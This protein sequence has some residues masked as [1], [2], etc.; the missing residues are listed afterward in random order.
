MN[1]DG[2]GCGAARCPSVFIGV[3][4]WLIQFVA[5]ARRGESVM[6]ESNQPVSRRDELPQ[7]MPAIRA[8]TPPGILVGRAGPTYRT[9]TQ[10]ALRQDHA[11]T[12]DAVQAELSIE[13]DFGPDFIQ[14]WQ[15]F[16]VSTCAGSK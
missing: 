16:E 12:V 14:H 3:H 13:R 10:L 6:P 1:T 7:W 11:A 2:H 9:S 8:R 15:L 5:A 4:P